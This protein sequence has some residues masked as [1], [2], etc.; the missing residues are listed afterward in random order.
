[1]R[2]IAEPCIRVSNSAAVQANKADSEVA[3]S[4]FRTRLRSG[5]AALR[6]NLFQGQTSWQSSQP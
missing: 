3:S 5:C 6:A 2:R 4:P 1:M